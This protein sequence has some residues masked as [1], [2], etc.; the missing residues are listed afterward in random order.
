MWI[1]RQFEPGAVHHVIAR[2]IDRDFLI[3]DEQ[4]RERYLSLLGRAMTE[5]DWRCLAFA[6]MSSHVHLAMIGGRTPAERWLRR[7]HPP[8]AAWLNVRL[9]RIGPVFTASP[10]IWVMR[11]DQ[12]RRLVAYLHNNPV[13]AGVVAHARDSHWTSH[14]AYLGHMAY[15]WLDTSAGL[16]RLGFGAHEL[17]AYV[18]AEVGYAPEQAALDGIRRAARKRGAVEVGTPTAGTPIAAPLVARLSTHVRPEPDDVLRLVS[19]VVGVAVARLRS[20]SR[21]RAVMTARTIALQCG[22]A[23]GLSVASV[24]SALGFSAQWGSKLALR[25]LQESER[26]AVMVSIARAEEEISRMLK[27]AKGSQVK[28]AKLLKR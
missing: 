27:K 7:V 28:A 11:A 20:K 13:R 1:V 10:A 23:L 3:P 6:I 24:A 26:A 18:E 19:E 12:E 9:A 8:Y 4:A 21:E 15:P 22:R 5:S 16:E 25:Q 2:F 14:R 17:D